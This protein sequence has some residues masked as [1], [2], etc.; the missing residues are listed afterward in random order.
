MNA[1]RKTLVKQTVRNFVSQL[2]MS[3]CD[4]SR[5]LKL[6]H[7]ECDI[8]VPLNGLDSP[9]NCFLLH[10]VDEPPSYDVVA[11]ALKS[12]GL[13]VVLCVTDATYTFMQRLPK[14][15]NVVLLSPFDSTAACDEDDACF[16][17]NIAVAMVEQL[18]RNALHS[19][20]TTRPA[21]RNLFH[22]RH[23]ESQLISQGQRPVVVLYGPQGSGKTSLIRHIGRTNDTADFRH[24]EIDLRGHNATA[25]LS[26]FTEY[27][28]RSGTR[29]V[30]MLDNVS[31]DCMITREVKLL[32][33]QAAF[34]SC[35]VVLALDWKYFDSV[36]QQFECEFDEIPL[37][38]FT[39]GEA[40]S[41]IMKTFSTIGI[42]IHDESNT[43]ESIYE[44]SRGWPY[45]LQHFAIESVEYCKRVGSETVYLYRLGWDPKPLLRRFRNDMEERR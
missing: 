36:K 26:A 27:V 21:G 23:R 17:D 44:S 16:E 43:L 12:S 30:V 15:K 5:H 19:F 1:K 40:R 38:P 22:G 45:I 13:A 20:S 28:V 3:R 39:P 8:T 42:R 9:V 4:T 37:G 33:K 14:I 18:G 7:T 2:N 41:F 25:S 24:V 34:G 35:R 32:L 11:N 31:L 10:I 29:P 6:F